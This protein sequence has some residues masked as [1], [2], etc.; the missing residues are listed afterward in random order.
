[1]KPMN[2]T[3]GYGG[4]S[5]AWRVQS[6]IVHALPYVLL[7]GIAVRV[8]TWFGWLIAVNQIIM[9]SCRLLAAFCATPFARAPTRTVH[10]RGA[11]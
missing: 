8:A 1:M 11:A 6:A 3:A 2:S 5:R 10:G 7:A 9:Q 4:E